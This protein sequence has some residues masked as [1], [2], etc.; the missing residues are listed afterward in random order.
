MKKIA[1]WLGAALMAVGCSQTP[2]TGSI[3]AELSGLAADDSMMVV[4]GDVKDTLAAPNGVFNFEYTD[5]VAQ[6][7][8][9]YKIPKVLPDGRIEAFGMNPV[10]VMMYPN[11]Q[12]SVKGSMADFEVTGN[13]FYEEYNLAKAQFATADSV[14]KAI[15]EEYM[16]LLR[17]QAPREEIMAKFATLRQADS[18][19]QHQ[20]VEYVGTH[21]DSDVS[22]F[23]LTLNRAAEGADIIGKFSDK[24]KQGAL[25]NFFENLSD[26]YERMTAR[27]KA[28]EFIKVG[29]PAPDF[30]LKNLEGEDF[31]LSSLRGK[32]VVLDFWGSWCG[33]CIKGFPEMK[34]MYEKYK[35]KLEIVGIDC[36]DTEAKWKAAVAKHEL[37]WMNVINGSDKENDMTTVYNIGGFPTKIIISPEGEIVDIVV[38]EK[39]EFYDTIKKLIKK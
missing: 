29:K 32:Y 4:Y 22:L 25:K 21:L 15:N 2:Q 13:E 20:I 5:S 6:L 19:Y 1:F 28:A 26:Y 23:L 31:K 14:R 30:V 38:G 8:N 12:L 34:K 17:A 24:V 16:T 9:F 37:P 33:W 36:K 11:E 35:G 18:I 10:F 39:P 27:M 7:V 3:K